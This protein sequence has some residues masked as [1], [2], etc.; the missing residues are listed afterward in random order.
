MSNVKCV[1]CTWLFALEFLLNVKKLC[2]VSHFILNCSYLCA[3]KSEIMSR[4]ITLL[5]LLT[6]GFT[7]SVQAK[8]YPKIKF[9]KTVIDFGD[10][11]VADGLQ[12]CTFTFAN[13]GEAPLVINYVHTSCGCTV[14]DY[15]KD[16]ISPG[17]KG[18]I[19][20]SYSG[21]GKTPGP[22][23]KT[24]QVFSNCKEDLARVSIKGNM[25]PLPREQRK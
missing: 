7:Q 5:L 15:P 23:T 16:P 9:D 22:F 8:K 11:T 14:A 21:E 19:K 17:G 25:L 10:F 18:I 2:K 13:V 20:V 4:I 1:L 3:I 12:T 6:L 24:I